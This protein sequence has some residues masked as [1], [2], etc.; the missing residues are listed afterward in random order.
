MEAVFLSEA[1]LGILKA[2]VEQK[3]EPT[4]T[5]WQELEAAA[6]EALDREPH[7]PAEW[8]VPLYYEDGE[9]HVKAK[10]GLQ[11]DANAAYS[12]ALAYRITDD[13]RYARAAVRLI[14]AW[15][16]EVKSLK[17]G[18]D[19]GL[20][21]SYHFPALI[22]AA[23]LLESAECWPV[24]EQ[25]VFK[26]FVREKALPINTMAR[27]NNWGNWGLVL[28]LACA[29]YTDDQALFDAG[30]T[31]W[32]EFIESQIA[33]DGHLIHEVNRAGN[34]RKGDYGIWYSNFSL[35]PQ[36][37]AAEILR[38]N[39]VDLYDYESPSGR[40]LRQAYEWL[41]PWIRQPKRFPYFQGGD[42]KQLVGVK[43]VSYFEILNAHWPDPYATAVLKKKRPLSANHSAPW[44]TFTHGALLDESQ[45]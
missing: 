17:S 14:N 22:F 12:L 45:E 38:V 4:L 27:D 25:A 34:K 6:D 30:A 3:V 16:T 20:S 2:R 42:R 5:A 29:A 35:F 9:G 32:K 39:G 18:E 33:D 40:S 26:R 11:D 8:F 44:L 10:Q 7:A 23:S 24:N 21:F 15:G 1:R 41:A 13:I 19:S 31:R 36:T 28:V 43:Y 37:I